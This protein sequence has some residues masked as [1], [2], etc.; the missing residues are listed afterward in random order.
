MLHAPSLKKIP[1]FCLTTLTN[2]AIFQLTVIYFCHERTLTDQWPISL[3]PHTA[4]STRQF[5]GFFSLRLPRKSKKKTRFVL[6]YCDGVS[7]FS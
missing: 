5:L 3:F 2:A 7:L 1:E 4:W 6:Q